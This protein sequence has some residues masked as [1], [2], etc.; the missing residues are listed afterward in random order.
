MGLGRAD[1][2]EWQSLFAQPIGLVQWVTGAI[3]VGVGWRRR[4]VFGALRFIPPVVLG[5]L[6]FKAVRLDAFFVLA[7][8]VMLGPLWAGLGPA[9]FPLSRRPVPSEVL[10]VA[11]IA[12]TGLAI[13]AHQAVRATSCLPVE[14]A[15]GMMPEPEAVVFLRS[16]GLQGKLLTWFDYGEYAIWHLAP[17]LRVSFDGRRE[18]VYSEHVKD[19]HLRFYDGLNPAYPDEIGADYVWLPNRLPVVKLLPGAAGCP[20]SKVRDRSSSPE[21]QASIRTWL[22]FRDRGV[23][24]VREWRRVG[25]DFI[26]RGGIQPVLIIGLSAIDGGGKAPE[27]AALERHAIR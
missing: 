25:I 18:T 5:L 12:I 6:A 16:N 2:T 20:S 7:A 1:I 3:V 14:S 9:R 19:A 10:V 13:V 17:Q 21:S 27:T 4:S 24:R 22:R 23:S 15:P 11:L 26:P 8:V